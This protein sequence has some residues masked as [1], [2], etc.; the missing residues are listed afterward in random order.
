MQTNLKWQHI[1]SRLGTGLGWE[2]VW[3]R[4]W[5]RIW[6]A[7][8]SDEYVYYLHYDDGYIYIYIYTH[9]LKHCDL[10]CSDYHMS[11]IIALKIWNK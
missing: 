9:M 4:Y 11:I 7:F 10:I 8:G 3:G 5:K 6:E 2:E 1:S